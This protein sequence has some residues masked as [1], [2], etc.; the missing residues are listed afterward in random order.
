MM[1][2]AAGE[3]LLAG[4]ERF[5]LRFGSHQVPRPSFRATWRDLAA[6]FRRVRDERPG[7]FGILLEN[8]PLFCTTMTAVIG[9]G[10]SAAMLAP[11]LRPYELSAAVEGAAIDV[12]VTARSRRETLA[13]LPY[14]CSLEGAWELPPWGALE[15]W[16]VGDRAGPDSTIPGELVCQFTSGVTGESRVASRSYANVIDETDNFVATVAFDAT[17]V[18]LCPAPLFHA[19]GLFNGLVPSLA[20]GAT[21]VA[22]RRF[23]PAEVVALTREHR[24]TILI[25]VP[26]MYEMLTRTHLDGQVDFSCY[27]ACFSAGA[28]LAR[29]VADAFEARFGVRIHQIYGSTETG[30]MCVNLPGDEPFDAVS[31]GRP[32]RGRSIAVVDEAGRPL[33]AGT[34]GEITVQSGGTMVGYVGRQDLS[35]EKL[36]DGRYFTGDVGYLDHLG[37]L[38][39]TGR[40]SGFVNVAG[41]KVDPHEVEAVMM[42]SGLVTECAVVGVPRPNFGETIRACVVLRGA[43]TAEQ[44]HAWCAERLSS[45]KL[46][47]DI[48][49]VDELPRSPTGKILRKYLV[50]G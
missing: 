5:K 13:N 8:G 3:P 46:P 39:I 49:V 42:S 19:Y 31:V 21:F 17:D 29:P 22:E 50:R 38:Y 6:T 15:L 25:G 7:R 11:G 18:V 48:R 12:L 33:P 26:F 28:K 36:R 10:T 35:R 20:T 47:R 30:I 27:R 1:P 4:L 45:F 16:A 40:K 14:P 44:V 34:E 37:R 23:F 2:T 32:V 41:R 9:S 43:A 24:P